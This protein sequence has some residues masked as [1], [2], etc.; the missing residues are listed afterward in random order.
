VQNVEVLHNAGCMQLLRPLL[1]DSVPNIQQ[2]AALALSRL[3]GYSEE[4]A[5]AI[6][7]ENI[8]IQLVYSLRFSIQPFQ[9][10]STGRPQF[11]SNV[12]QNNATETET[13]K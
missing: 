1:L 4:L 9:H 5:E 8:L 3:A 7:H 6:V 12:S 2:T 10:L 13:R 11:E